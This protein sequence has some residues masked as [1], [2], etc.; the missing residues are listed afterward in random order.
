[1]NMKSKMISASMLALA[2]ACQ[3][4]PPR[5]L[6]SGDDFA[7]WHKPSGA[8]AAHWTQRDGRLACHA[9]AAPIWTEQEFGDFEI[10]LDVR[11]V[12]GRPT[13]VL[14]ARGAKGFQI[15][16]EPK[17]TGEWNHIKVRFDG[18]AND[19]DVDG[20]ASAGTMP[21]VAKSGAI[22]LSVEGVGSVEF[23]RVLVHDLR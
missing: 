13:A 1:M 21:G 23:A 10:T 22:G 18:E 17:L 6:L 9:P 2:V 7:G 15:A 4:V 12:E 5:P 11:L 3:S 16:L 19:V 8:Q 20:Q 14:F